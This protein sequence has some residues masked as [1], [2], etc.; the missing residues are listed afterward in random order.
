M[1]YTYGM[2]QASQDYVGL[3]KEGRFKQQTKNRINLSLLAWILLINMS[4]NKI[5]RSRDEAG[6]LF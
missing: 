3:S 5:I 2:L 6:I 1:D 4:E